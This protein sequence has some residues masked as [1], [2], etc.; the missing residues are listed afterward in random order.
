M[1]KS[2]SNR[3]ARRTLPCYFWIESKP[4]ATAAIR[5]ITRLCHMV[6]WSKIGRIMIMIM[7][8]QIHVRCLLSRVRDTRRDDGNGVSLSVTSPDNL[9]SP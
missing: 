7:A 2:A 4:K 3:F 5:S 9:V 8:S 1:G 6:D